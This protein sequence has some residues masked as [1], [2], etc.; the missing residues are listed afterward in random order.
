MSED[1]EDPTVEAAV[2]RHYRVGGLMERIREG[3]AELGVEPTRPDEMPPFDELHIG[4]AA[5]TEALMAQVPLAPGMEVLDIGSGLG[6]TARYVVRRCGATVTGIDLT[7]ELVETARALSGMVG[8]GEATRFEV[9]SALDLPFEDARFDVALLIHVSMNIADKARLLAEA[10]RVLKPG[11]TIALYEVM[12][13]GEGEV[14]YPVPWAMDAETSFLATPD[15]YREAAEAAG[16]AVTAERDRHAFAVDFFAE[17]KAR[18]ESGDWPP[19]LG[20]QIMMGETTRER[21]GNL[22]A[23]LEAGR[24]APVEMI[25]RAE[26]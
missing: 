7:E 9:A 3:L 15:E 4:G 8:L 2:A 14:V 1:G 19:P 23:N 5:A 11:G 25:L 6:G 13:T 12:R 17:V 20:P 18:M 24:V 16:F 26:G 22:I 21:V 10:R